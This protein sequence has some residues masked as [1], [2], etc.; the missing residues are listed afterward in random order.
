MPV[1]F[2]P[3]RPYRKRRSFWWPTASGVAPSSGGGSSGSSAPLIAVAFDL[4]DPFTGATSTYYLSSGECRGT[5]SAARMQC[6]PVLDLPIRIGSAI[7]AESFG[8]PIAVNTSIGEIR[9]GLKDTD[10]VNTLALLDLEWEGRAFRVYEGLAGQEFQSLTH[11]FTGRVVN[12]GH[13][14]AN[15]ARVLVTDA[16][17]DLDVPLVPF[18]YGQEFE[19]TSAGFEGVTISAS[20]DTITFSGG[21]LVAGANVV[22]GDVL[23]FTRGLV[24]ENL[25]TPLTVL[26]VTATTLQMDVGVGGSSGTWL[27][28][29]QVAET[30]RGR[31]KM[32]I[33]GTC[34]NVEPVLIT[35]ATLE[36]HV[37]YRRPI[38]VIAVR[39]GGI[40][41]NENSPTP[42][43]GEWA[44]NAGRGTII[45]G[46][47]P[48][49]GEV[50]CDVRSDDYATMTTAVFVEEIVESKGGAVDAAAFAALEVSAPTRLGYRANSN[51]SCRFAIDE[52][53]WGIV[54]Y[55]GTE[56]L[57]EITIGLQNQPFGSSADLEL[58][59]L[60]IARLSQRQRVTPAYKTAA[61]Y[62]RQW[63]PSI[64]FF[65]GV[66]EED[67]A[68]YSG[69][70]KLT[71]LWIDDQIKTRNPRALDVPPVRTLATSYDDAFTIRERFISVIGLRYSIYDVE[72]RCDAPD[73]YDEVSILYRGVHGLSGGAL[74]ARVL[75]WQREIGMTKKVSLVLW[76]RNFI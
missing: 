58:T 35:A 27:F 31:S 40:V 74:F 8:S 30:A 42:G 18:H 24:E 20:G 75:S 21:D 52:A 33:W 49:G 51:V 48:A 6:L 60:N 59:E 57:G 54:G 70:D 56:P 45:L 2:R 9:F 25:D 15:F 17:L 39:V 68:I 55:W 29:Q 13:D 64:Q 19:E 61:T 23:I 71:G 14:G 3:R 67:R 41:W 7:S 16:S 65:D 4:A 12:I 72:A 38:E 28:Y 10:A 36:Y 37:S 44:Q 66:S 76:G 62:N 46:S 22:A 32:A 53:V 50:R 63:D 11:I 1:V 47:D 69:Q 34:L 43:P 26:A 5:V 73:L